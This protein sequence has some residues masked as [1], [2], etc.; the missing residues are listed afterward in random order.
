MTLILERFKDLARDPARTTPINKH[1][2]IK[3]LLAGQPILLSRAD[4]AQG[5]LSRI[6]LQLGEKYVHVQGARCH[7]FTA[8]D[9]DVLLRGIDGL[10]I[11]LTSSAEE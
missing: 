11:S 6:L 9:V 4:A 2:A 7:A 5:V 3:M 1:E 10:I 8:S